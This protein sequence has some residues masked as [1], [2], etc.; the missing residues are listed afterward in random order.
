M[1]EDLL[2]SKAWNLV[3]GK[4]M[5]WYEG[6]LTNLPNLLLA[7]LI[8]F[9]FVFV[10]K[11][12]RR[13]G[14]RVMQRSL[15]N[16]MALSSLF[17]TL[18]QFGVI[19]LGV[20]V[21]LGVLNLDKTV[22]SLLA[23][24]GVL[25]IALGFAFQDIAANLISGVVIAIKE[26]FK[27]GNIIEVDGIFGE[28]KNIDLRT[29]LI[30]TF[31]GIEIFVPNKFMFEKP[32]HNFSGVPKR[33]LD[34]EVGVSYGDD[35]EKVEKVL[36]ECLE[37]LEGR[38]EEKPLEIFYKEFGSSSINCDVRIWVHYP[39]NLNYLKVR[40][41]AVKAIKKAFDANDITIPFPIRT[42]DFGIKGGENLR[43]PLEHTFS[44]QNDAHQ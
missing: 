9:V 13:A 16:N 20:F 41:A 37:E 35:L 30:E 31:Q 23:G 3:S 33:R 36:Y 7:G 6:L 17:S 25:G 19:L 15:R 11:G 10:S 24:A 29:T 26:P 18:L 2:N 44:S 43:T 27:I 14:H 12:V 5:Q 4:L 1:L 34:I 39:K 38:V 32:L 40:H 42:L 28:V 21:A 8:I 22:T